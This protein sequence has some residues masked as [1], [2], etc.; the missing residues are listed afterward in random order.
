MKRNLLLVLLLTISFSTCACQ[1]PV[2]STSVKVINLPQ[3]AEKI[4]RAGLSNFY[5]VSDELY[6]GAQ[7]S[8]EGVAQLKATGIKTIVNLRSF[9][10][11]RDEIGGIDIGYEHIYVKSWHP[12]EE[13]LVR[14]LQIVTDENR[15][16]VFVHCQHGADRTGLF[17]AVYRAAVCGWSKED[18]LD[19]MVEGPFGFHSVWQSLISYFDELDIEDIKQKAGLK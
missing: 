16:P 13:D 14:F 10:S 9:H 7:P 6:R 19:E 2:K 3:W 8:A 18:A 4:D 1:Q 15:T 5:K 12:E 11:D 17:C